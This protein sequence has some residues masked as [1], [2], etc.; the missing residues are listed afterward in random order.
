MDSMEI[1]KNLDD[2][3][4]DRFMKLEKMFESDGWT[5]IAEWAATQAEFAHN[6]AAYAGSWEENRMAVGSE[7]VYL[8]V[9]KLRDAVLQEFQGIAEAKLAE[10]EENSEDDMISH[11]S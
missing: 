9:A 3:Q 6:A 10:A 4:T 7:K 8:A 1:I 11:Q 5:L 2:G